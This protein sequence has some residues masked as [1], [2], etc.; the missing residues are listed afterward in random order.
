M[1]LLTKIIQFLTAWL[2][3]KK[4][5]EPTAPIIPPLPISPSS[6]LTGTTVTEPPKANPPLPSPPSAS[7]GT[8]LD[9]FM[10]SVPLLKVRGFDPYTVLTHAWHETGGFGHVVGNNNFFGIT[11]PDGWKGIVLDID[12]HE[13]VKYIVTDPKDPD[14]N[15][16]AIAYAKKQFPNITKFEIQPGKPGI[17]WVKVTTTRLFV[18]WETSDEAVIWYCDKIQRMY[19]QSY[20]FRNVPDKYFFWLVNGKYQWATDPSYVTELNGVY[21]KVT[22]LASIKVKMDGV[23]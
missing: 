6:T 2:N 15:N 1:G 4:P 22:A 18:D 16:K 13:F 10:S 21:A 11:K 8:P 17:L 20:S 19:P 5:A 23:A 12:T 14:L 7:W 3:P 9:R